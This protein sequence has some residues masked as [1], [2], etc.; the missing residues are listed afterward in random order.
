MPSCPPCSSAATVPH[1]RSQFV[2]WKQVCIAHPVPSSAH[3][4]LLN[5]PAPP[6]VLPTP[7]SPLLTP[8]PLHPAPP[9]TSPCRWDVAYSGARVVEMQDGH[10]DCIHYRMRPLPLGPGPLMFGPRDLCLRRYWQ[11]TGDGCYVVLYMSMEH[12]LC[13][14]VMGCVRARIIYGGFFVAPVTGQGGG[15][16]RSVCMHVLQ[17]EAK[18]GPYIPCSGVTANLHNYLLSRVAGEGDGGA[19]SLL[20]RGGAGS[21]LLGVRSCAGGTN[22]VDACSG[23]MP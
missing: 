18:G 22:L 7:L 2:L 15:Q 13:P 10:T 16:A 14:P 12:P 9:S 17:M 19:G 20:G 5:L 21:V 11:R 1:W 3:P 4:R 8:S 23:V 6:F